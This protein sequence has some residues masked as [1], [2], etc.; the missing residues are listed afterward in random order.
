MSGGNSIQNAELEPAIIMIKLILIIAGSGDYCSSVF[1][2]KL[3]MKFRNPK[4]P[5]PLTITKVT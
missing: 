4:I 2:S 1:P 3:K 5:L